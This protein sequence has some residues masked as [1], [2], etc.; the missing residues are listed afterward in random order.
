LTGSGKTIKKII[1]L[2]FSESIYILF[3]NPNVGANKMELNMKNLKELCLKLQ[4]KA[5]KSGEF[6][7]L[8]ACQEVGHHWNELGFALEKKPAE[9]KYDNF[10]F[11]C[12]DNPN[13]EFY[14]VKPWRN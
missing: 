13:S 14:N 9:L 6:F 11:K 1:Y 8:N 7:R 2:N 10:C 3:N 12:Y 4:S 5:L